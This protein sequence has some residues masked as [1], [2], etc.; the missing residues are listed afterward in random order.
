M[1]IALLPEFDLFGRPPVQHCVEREIVTEH[2][3][4]T[5]VADA[6]SP[7][8]FH[9]PCNDN[10]YINLRDLKLRLQLQFDINK[11]G[12]TTSADWSKVAPENFLL[13][14]FFKDIQL[15]IDDKLITSSQ[16]LYSYKAMIETLIGFTP[17]AMKTHLQAAGWSD[18][19]TDKEHI[20]P[21]RSNWITPLTSATTGKRKV[22]DLFGKLYLDMCFQHRALVGGSSLKLTFIPQSNKFYIHNLIEGAKITSTIK[23]I[24]LEVTRSK[25]TPPL[26]E[27]HIAAMTKSPARYPH[28]RSEMK[29]YNLAQGIKGENL[30]NIVL[31]TLPRRAVVAFVSHAGFN[32]AYKLNPYNFKPYNLS[33]LSFHLDGES[34][35]SRPFTPNFKDGLYLREYLSVFDAYNQWSSDSVCNFR[36][37]TYPYGY[38]LLAV[39]F[40]P[41]SSD[42]CLGSGH[43]SPAKRGNLR[44]ELK[45]AEALPEPVNCLIYLE[46]DANIE[47]DL[48]KIVRTN[49]M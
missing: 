8:T 48:D 18:D 23:D 46:Y 4:Y 29:V 44:L 9:V 42:G 41:D 32:G 22:I 49:Y 45:F 24:Y 6:T 30:D 33:Y 7:I 14:S 20:S 34:Y 13:H 26:R 21:T 40:S 35:P 5:T 36:R 47:I 1:S 31:G 19:A 27:A 28:T 37:D 43:I 2:R 38:A 3:P 16:P 25:V 11:T 17:D 12:D 39:N 10:E 15:E